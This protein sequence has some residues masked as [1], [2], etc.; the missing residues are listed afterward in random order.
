MVA[1]FWL[2]AVVNAEDNLGRSSSEDAENDG[3]PNSGL[4]AGLCMY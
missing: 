1:L 3:D 2:L 4:Y